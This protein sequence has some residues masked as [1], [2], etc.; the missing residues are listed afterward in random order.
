MT[1]LLRFMQAMF[2]CEFNYEPVFSI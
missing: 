1:N 2:L